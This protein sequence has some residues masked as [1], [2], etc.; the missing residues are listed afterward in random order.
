MI[1]K[2]K[3]GLIAFTCLFLSISADDLKINNIA[4]LPECI[5]KDNIINVLGYNEVND[6]GGGLFYWDEKSFLE[7][8]NGMVIKCKDYKQGRYIRVFN[9][10]VNLKWFG[11]IGDGKQDDSKSF[12]DFFNFLM[13]GYIGYIP[14]GKYLIKN[15]I[16]L[17]LNNDFSIDV[18]NNAM[19]IGGKFNKPMF[20]F[21]GNGH[22]FT[23]K[24]GKLDTSRTVFIK[25]RQSG[26]A[27]ALKRFKK[28]SLEDI[29]FYAD[30]HYENSQKDNH[31][32]S[33]ITI[34]NS[35][36][37]LISKN[38]FTG[39]PDAAIYISGGKT[40]S[41]KDDGGSYI[42]TDNI[43]ENS[44]IGITIKRE[45]NEIL[46]SNNIFNGNRLGVT[47]FDTGRKERYLKPGENI[48]IINNI[49]KKTESTAI[50]LRAGS[51]NLINNNVITDWGYDRYG[52]ISKRLRPAIW[53]RGI[54]DSMILNNLIVMKDWDFTVKHKKIELINYKNNKRNTKTVKSNNVIIKNNSVEN[55]KSW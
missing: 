3:I 20:A 30:K 35:K 44:N 26:T 18:N 6:Q 53:L 24:G 55:N 45:V 48:L 8:Y 32:D 19:F 1:L 50:E 46:I 31:A 40:N 34:V 49:F 4:H 16:I 43:F 37:V 51:Y 27:L 36:N 47:T 10:K 54:S 5:Y 11:A 21:D 33:G 39:F 14:R 7:E 29:V 42:I 15:P 9:T 12:K 38:I 41:I 22:T 2:L 52:K 23:W 28:I 17:K 13:K 25:A